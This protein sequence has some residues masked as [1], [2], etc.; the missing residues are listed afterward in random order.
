MN[1]PS[2]VDALALRAADLLQ[3]I[4]AYGFDGPDEPLAFESRLADDQGWTLGYAL[5]VAEEYRRF[6]VLTQVADHAV[7][8]SP[9]VDEAW[10][11]HLTRTAHYEAFCAAVFGR[12]L[13]HA[14]ARSG[15]GAK[16]RDMYAATLE[17]YRA[18][19]GFTAPPVIWP[20]PGQPLARQAATVPGWTVPGP[21]RRHRRLGH[22]ALLLAGVAGVLLDRV[23]LLHPLQGIGPVQFLAGALIITLALGWLGLRSGVP[24]VQATARDRLEPYE[25]AWFSGGAARMAMTAIAALTERGVLLAPGK[26]PERAARPLIPV[27][28]TVE[29][30]CVHPAEAVCLAMATD[31]GL[32]YTDACNALQPLA[33]EVEQRLVAAGIAADAAALPR[34]RAQ[35]LLG[36]EIL[37]VVEVARIAHALGT[38]HPV[39]FLVLLTL[40]GMGLAWMLARRPVRTSARSERVLRPLR[41]A[42][43]IHGKSPRAGQALAFG[44]ALIGGTAIAGDLRFAGLD[45]QVD[46][47]GADWALRQRRG[48]GRDDSSDG[49]NSCGSSCGSSD[50]GS[51]TSCSGGGSSCSSGSSCGSGCGGGGD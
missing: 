32:R 1:A 2:Q 4:E 48:A 30:R 19:F 5:A 18:A 10:H 46:V 8:P 36:M 13:H 15:E 11:L 28:R 16:H 22:A 42:A 14:P 45:Q 27:N 41:L 50:A 51:A 21:L 3:R 43:G 7:S 20:R 31:A 44:V 26:V 37:L 35:A 12:F 47:S 49:S 39:G 6:L 40:A 17:A 29:A 24:P 25:A 9:D 34:P 38:P 23:G 33:A